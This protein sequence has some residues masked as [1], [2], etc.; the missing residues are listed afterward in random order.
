M[1]EP[2]KSDDKKSAS[3]PDDER[4][5]SQKAQDEI[6]RLEKL[7][8]EWEVFE[9][10]KALLERKR[11]RREYYGEFSAP[12]YFINDTELEALRALARKNKE[13]WLFEDEY[14][15]GD[16][17]TKGDEGWLLEPA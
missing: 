3:R 2:D 4:T 14:L 15:K 17:A 10:P 11:A 8:V 13:Q 6:A 5:E 9:S 7:K 16:G 1:A 12:E